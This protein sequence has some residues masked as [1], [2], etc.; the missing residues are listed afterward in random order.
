MREQ[1][2]GDPLTYRPLQARREHF[3]PR[4]GKVASCGNHRDLLCVGV[5]DGN[6]FIVADPKAGISRVAAK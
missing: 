2:I 1:R 5:G 3:A 4:I 6:S